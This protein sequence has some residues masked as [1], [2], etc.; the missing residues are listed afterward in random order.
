M[1]TMGDEVDK[2]MADDRE[3]KRAALVATA[4]IGRAN[5]LRAGAEILLALIQGRKRID[6]G[7]LRAAAASMS[8]AADKVEAKA[9]AAVA[10]LGGQI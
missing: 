6:A 9:N 10:K 4:D 5:G 7:E 3:R 2:L 8:D 1:P